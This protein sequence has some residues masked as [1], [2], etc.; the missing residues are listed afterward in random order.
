[1]IL[2]ITK[3]SSFSP[4]KVKD[5]PVLASIG[6]RTQN[7]FF[8]KIVIKIQDSGQQ[9]VLARFNESNQGCF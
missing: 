2:E 6:I 5:G 4:G 7:S 8:T 3:A 9:S 1:M